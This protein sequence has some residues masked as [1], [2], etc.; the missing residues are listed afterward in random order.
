MFSRQ[1]RERVY[2]VATK[3]F[4]FDFGDMK[5]KK[6]IVDIDFSLDIP[7]FEYTKEKYPKYF[8]DKVNLDKIKTGKFYQIRRVYLR[9]LDN[10]PTLTANMGTGGHNVPIIKTTSGKTRKLSPRECFNLMGFPKDF[11]LPKIANC[12]L[13]KQSGNSVI[14]TLVQNI[15]SSLHSQILKCNSITT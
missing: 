12:H 11:K 4:K 3:G 9:E 10:C 14:I 2:I 5:S 15:A 1:M 7:E 6:E 8:S 13:Y